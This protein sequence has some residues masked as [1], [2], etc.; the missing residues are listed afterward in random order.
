MPSPS[1]SP[2]GFVPTRQ[3][4][5][6]DL[7]ALLLAVKPGERAMVAIDGV[8][9]VGKTHLVR[10]LLSLA[11]HVSGR[12]I[13]AVSIDG[14]HRPRAERH[15][16]GST[17]QTFYRDS[18]DYEAFRGAVVHPFRNGLEV[19]PAAFDV[20][21]DEPVNPDPIECADDAILLVDGIFLRRP[22]LREIWDASVWVMAPFHVTVPRGNARFP[23]RSTDPEHLD[24]E[25]CVDGQGLY[26]EQARLAP[27]TW[28]LDNTHLD[29]PAL[30]EPDPEDPQWFG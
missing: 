1:P 16:D 6:V 5:L 27:P 18:Y 8:D 7:L 25:R 10:E 26:I 30:I 12:E 14:F 29:R 15:A 11:P 2:Y 17:A 21:A 23:G 3:L 22:E 20:A 24:N 19:R 4:V 28:I 13:V 9:G